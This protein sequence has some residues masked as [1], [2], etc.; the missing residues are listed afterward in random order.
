M[1]A[2]KFLLITLVSCML[3]AC[4][5]DNEEKLMTDDPVELKLSS[6]LDLQTRADYTF[7]QGSQIVAYEKVYAWVDEVQT[8]SVSEYVQAW[9]LTAGGSGSLSGTT[10]FYPT[11]GNNVNVYA[12]HGN[13]TAPTGSFPASLSHSVSTSQNTEYAKS[14]LLFGYKTGC[15][16]QTE[17]H[18]LTFTH[19]LSKI[20][21]YLIAGT[22]MTDA[23]LTNAT[24]YIQNTLPTTTVSFNKTAA[25]I[26]TISAATGTA[27]DITAK[28]Q[29][30]TDQQ[31]TV[32]GSSKYAYAFGEAIIIPQ[33]VN[34][35][36]AS[37]GADVDF[38]KITLSGGGNYIAQVNKEFEAGKKYT[39]YVTVN[40]SGLTLSSTITNWTA[41]TTTPG[42]ISAQ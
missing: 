28:M 20:E 13:F 32:S 37:G 29:Y 42:E 35:T 23:N 39:Y 4:G 11:S 6:G 26:A 36:H 21:V 22:G 30:Q 2:D 3:T 14:D 1:K 41:G 12:V 25:T 8:S 24:V 7:T 18:Q 15:S 40:A 9:E 27:S 34:D 31:V 38:V 5:N 33:W 19:L 16:R 10:K 17:A